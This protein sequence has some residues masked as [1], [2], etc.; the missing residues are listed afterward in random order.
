MNEQHSSNEALSTAWDALY[1]SLPARWH[2][3]MPTYDA[4]RALWSVTASGPG[5]A[6]REASQS[7]TGKGKSEAAALRDL[8]GRLRAMPSPNRAR[9]DAFR[10]RLRMA[11]VDR[12]EAV[13]RENFDRGLTTSELGRIIRRYQGS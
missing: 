10:H 3:G 11:H 12:A 9:I 8:D 13:S 7:L 4:A 6:G 2:I 1:D 5:V